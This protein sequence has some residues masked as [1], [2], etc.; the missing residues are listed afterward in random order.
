GTVSGWVNGGSGYPGRTK[1]FVYGK[2]NATPTK[3]GATV[4]GD[5]NNSARY[6]AFN[7]SGDHKT[8]ELRIASSFISA[9]QAKKNYG[10]ELEGV[11]FEAAHDAVTAAWNERLEVV[12]DV[13][14]ASDNQLVTLYSSLYRLNLYPNSQFENT[15][16]AEDPTYQYA[17][18]VSAN[19]GESASDPNRTA[20][21]VD[22]KIYVNNGFWDTYRTAWPAYALLYPE[23][24]EE[25]VDG[26]VEQY[27]EGGW[28][29]RWSSPG[30]ADLMTGTSSDVA[31]AEAYLAGSLSTE[32]ALEAYDAAVKNATVLPE[33]NAVGR[34][35][36]DTSIFLGYTQ[37]STHESASWG[38]EGFINDFGIAEMA[39]KL[40][41][42]PATPADRKQQLSEEAEYFEARAKHYVE[43]YNPD[44]GMFTA[45]NADGSWPSSFD[46]KAW[47]GAFTEASGWTFAFHAPH[48]VDGLAALYGGRQGLVDELH[49][50]L[51]VRE[52]ADHSGI[53]E[54]REARDV[55]LGML[56]MSNQVAHHIPYVLAEAGDPSGAQEL[57]RDIQQRLF[58]GSD[59]GQGYP[60]DE[61]NGEFSSW[62]LFSALGFYPLEVGS[63]NYTIGSP[64]FDSATVNINGKALTINAPGASDGKVYVDGVTINDTAI[65]ETTFDGDLIRNGGTVTFTM[66]DTPSTWGAKDLTEDLQ[67]PEVMVDATKPSF[68]TL[69]AG[70]GT[71]VGRLVDDSM[72]SAVT[73]AGDT[74]ELTWKSSSGPV[75]VHQYT[76]TST[77]GEGVGD[78]EAWTLEGSADGVNW[79]ELDSREGQT[80]PLGTQTRPFSVTTG[81]AAYTQYR[82]KISSA[83]G[84]TLGLTELELFARAASASELT[85]V[86][87][88]AQQV[89]VGA[90][91]TGQVAT[92]TGA[93]AQTLE[94]S[95][96]YGDGSEPVA[97]VVSDNGL[98]GWTVTAPHTFTTA[99]VYTANVSAKDSSGVAVS[100]QTQVSVTRDDT[101]VG[102][103]NNACIGSVN[104]QAGDCDAQTHSYDVSQLEA[105]GFVQ[106][107]TIAIGTTGLTF[108]LPDVPLGQPDNVTGEGQ[109]I[110]V[111]LGE[112]ATKISLIAT[113]TESDKERVG[114]LTFSDGTTQELPIKVGDWVGKANNPV[115]GNAVVGTVDWRLR[116][117]V[118]EPTNDKKSAIFATA[119]V[120]LAKNDDG[121]V[122]T[123][124]SLTMPTEP[125]TLRAQG[126]VHVFAIG[127][128]G[129]RSEQA[130]LAVTAAEVG[131]QKPGVEFEAGLATAAG[132][133]GLDEAT[134][135]V[136]WGDGTPVSPVEVTD[137]AVS[138]THTYTEAGTY[139]VWVTVDDGVQSA[140]ASLQIVVEDDAPVYAP[141]ITLGAE[142]VRPG[143]TVTV[144]GTGF[145]P[146]EAVTVTL[147]T[148]DPVTVEAS[149]EGAVSA[150]LTVPADAADGEYPV[151]ALGAVS[152]VEAGTSVR[153][154]AE[155]P[156]PVAT[157][158]TLAASTESPVAGET[159]QL[160]AT[161]APSDAAG[162]V[163]F[164][165]GEQ[166]VGS[167]QV[168]GGTATADV[169]AATS[170]AHSYTARFV[171][172]DAEAFAPSVSA[173][174]VLEVRDAP[175]LAAELELSA[176]TVAQGGSFAVIGRGY[177]PGETVTV[178][179]HSDPVTLGEVVVDEAGTFRLAATV[180]AA[181]E[182]GEHTVVG[183]GAESEL[184]AEAVLTVTPAGSDNG[185]GDG[186]G[187]G[188]GSGDG[189]GKPGAGKPGSGWLPTTGAGVAGLIA[190][191]FGLVVAGGVTLAVRRRM[192]S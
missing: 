159:F 9:D 95:V 65:T 136:N 190:A 139:T 126:R 51:T 63:G 25:L 151:V 28:I 16:T 35:G 70:D 19:E 31:F 117:T 2:F 33:S 185:S 43:M 141:E 88:E 144:S 98:G 20:K 53:H 120:E 1:M 177:A 106:G 14:G 160:T 71:A 133:F 74:A 128:D 92:V 115:F 105:T 49:E 191:M 50:F 78:P 169:R 24:S 27:R 57:I 81:E 21:I 174:L 187:S 184:V 59:I 36:L 138:G 34:K 32:L 176:S 154:E 45:R 77:T 89:R 13:Q 15:G 102:A 165:D 161:V 42:D 137:G 97:G 183:T 103:F 134:A 129:E 167:A 8:V 84:A 145:A 69:T 132:G 125:G 18:P 123:V 93:D 23:Q 75:T 40:A 47:G 11:S 121:T 180:P 164:L 55:R 112:G 87:A 83:S 110:A 52:M 37:A 12:T 118:K 44:A 56:G 135:T 172:A 131:T 10:L 68:G 111:N 166:V 163:E 22:G 146:G 148:N 186:D 181:A 72:N 179:L 64:L 101:L 116:G 188:N 173:A 99:G 158:V 48:D 175:V 58:V 29:A 67:V 149:E 143:G 170:G 4:R 114:I 150:E 61:D 79:T 109:T 140:S 6:A 122:K 80:F 182:L 153:V 119:P 130:A 178:V 100:A 7:T 66:S 104:V 113:A 107:T 76:L 86:S 54:A 147:G 73:F 26:F 90:E 142:V 30:Y 155:V 127:S 189:T 17:S 3:S 41:E 96:D 171:P 108:D 38:L 94:V 39:K 62:F 82:L 156:G 85:I 168:S 46:R 157:S 162:Q 192:A 91:F 60:G 5:R 152:Q 124:V